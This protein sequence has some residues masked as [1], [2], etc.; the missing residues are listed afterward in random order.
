MVKE[1]VQSVWSTLEKETPNSQEENAAYVNAI[2]F[3]QEAGA[4]LEETDDLMAITARIKGIERPLKILLDI[5]S[6]ISAVNTTTVQQEEE[7]QGARVN[8]PRWVTYA[9]SSRQKLK[10]ALENVEMIETSSKRNLNIPK[11][12][13]EMALPKDYDILL[14]KDWWKSQKANIDWDQNTVRFGKGKDQKACAQANLV[15]AKLPDGQISKKQMKRILKK[16]PEIVSSCLVQERREIK[17]AR[18]IKYKYEE[19]RPDSDGDTIVAHATS[20]TLIRRRLEAI[21]EYKDQD[22]VEEEDAHPSDRPKLFLDQPETDYKEIDEILI[23]AH[24]NERFEMD[25]TADVVRRQQNPNRLKAMLSHSIEIEPGVT[26][27]P[28]SPYR[29]MSWKEQEECKKIIA[30]YLETG[31]IRPSNSPYGAAVLFAPKKNGKLRFCVDWRPLNAITV[32]NSAHPADATDCINQLAGATIFSTIDLSSGYHQL[33]IVEKDKQKTAFNTKYGHYEFN[34]MSFGL[35]S[36]PAT[37]VSAMNRI[38]SG[39]MFRTGMGDAHSTAEQKAAMAALNPQ[40]KKKLG[41]NFLDSFVCVY[42]DDIIVFSKNP[43]EHAEHLRKVFER[44]NE[45]DLVVSSPKSFFAQKEVEYLGHKISANGVHVNPEKIKAVAEWPQPQ[46]QTD[47]RQFLGLCNF[48]RKFI[49]GHSQIAKPLTDLTRKEAANEKGEIEMTDLAIQAFEKLKEALCT[50]PVLAIPDPARGKFHVMCDASTYGLGATLFQEGAEDKKQHPVAYISRVLTA[51]ERKIYEQERRIYELEL[52]A[53]MFSLEKWK[54]YLDGQV[55]TTVDTD[56]KSLIWLQSQKEL[57]PMQAQFLDTLARSDIKIKYIKGELNVPGDVLS[58]NPEFEKQLC[59]YIS[60]ELAEEMTASVKAYKPTEVYADLATW[61]ARIEEGYK[62]DPEWAAHE[63]DEHPYFQIE[64][65]KHKIWYK[66]HEGNDMPPTV[67]V[68]KAKGL[69]ELIINEHHAPP[70]VGH[71]HAEQTYNRIRKS[72]YWKN[73]KNEIFDQVKS[74]STCQENKRDRSGKKGKMA[75]AEM[76]HGPWSSVVVDFCG[77]YEPKE[78]DSKKMPKGNDQIMVV[79]CRLTKMA[80]FIPCK[81]TQTTEQL[82]DLYL[83]N[84]V[85]L[86]GVPDEFRSDRD[87]LF[88]AKFWARIWE[89]SGT[90]LA[91]STAYHHQTAGQAERTIQELNIYLR[92]YLKEHNEWERWLPMAEFAYNSAN[93]SSI[94]CSPFELNKGFRPKAPA[95]CLAPPVK[96]ATDAA[97]KKIEKAAN[98]WLSKI[99]EQMETAKE[100][101]NRAYKKSKAQYDKC[102][103]PMRDKEGKIKFAPVGSQVYLSTKEMPNLETVSQQAQADGHAEELKRKFLPTFVG[104]YEV[105]AVTGKGDLNRELKLPEKMK[106]KLKEKG[107][108]FH[109]DRL[110]EA[111]PNPTQQFNLDGELPPP[112]LQQESAVE[113][114]EFF[115]EKIIQWKDQTN[116]RWFRVKFVGYDVSENMWYHEQNLPNAQE[117]IKEFMEKN[118]RPVRER[119]VRQNATTRVRSKRRTNMVMACV[120]YTGVAAP[121]EATAFCH[122]IIK[123]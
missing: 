119:K 82:A 72:Y 7:L 34:L 107:N 33:P 94:G 67:C 58:R 20:D 86:H 44:L 118:P 115:I 74:C 51:T 43:K 13:F 38:F 17:L 54:I 37:F 32:K 71:R 28:H 1:Y 59:A 2:A 114:E 100:N 48:Y 9:N 12:L 106:Q 40:E 108:V 53:L 42:I 77:P 22:I 61:F 6:T 104:P 39:E 87:K 41:E 120:D 84:I 102:R 81:T 69:R 123:T 36:A 83:E 60:L 75:P 29:R 10:Y 111:H 47:I 24:K 112:T 76:P 30:Q 3:S 88:T 68:P 110:K 14:G 96:M 23:Q 56:H 79:A 66:V 65:E 85:R 25:L 89:R 93:H 103:K 80:H 45:Y 35:A 105:T 46:T 52:K 109:V 92:M 91:L 62:E 15:S 64:R 26:K 27:Q 11:T 90:S 121:S 97:G 95:D 50:A 8:R 116:G 55:G 5:G 117:L 113:E 49:K 57:S 21:L 101:L 70:T 16:H 122:L 73:M 99:N 78:K 63:K 19:W 4:K 31:V 98:A 18:K